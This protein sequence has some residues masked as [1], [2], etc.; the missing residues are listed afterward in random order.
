MD[1]EAYRKAKEWY[2]N[3]QEEL[4]KL[5][6]DELYKEYSLKA[7]AALPDS[8]GLK[9]A[10]AAWVVRQIQAMLL[11]WGCP[12]ADSEGVQMCEYAARIEASLGEVQ[13]IDELAAQSSLNQISE[14]YEA[15]RKD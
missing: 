10:D 14:A 8:A 9:V 5:P 1:L 11:E 4:E 7:I 12:K 3:N 15:A 13:S 2:T 6:V